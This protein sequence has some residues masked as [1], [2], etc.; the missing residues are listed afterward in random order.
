MVFFPMNPKT[1]SNHPSIGHGIVTAISA[2]AAARLRSRSLPNEP[3]EEASQQ[4][5]VQ[6]VQ[7]DFDDSEPEDVAPEIHHNLKLC[8]W[9]NDEKNVLSDSP[10]ELTILLNRN[11]TISLIGSYEIIVLKGAV[12]INGANLAANMRKDVVVPP[13]RVFVPLTHPISVVKGLD[14]RNEVCFTNCEIPTPL[15]D[16]SPL[17]ASIWN[18][19]APRDQKRSFSVVS[20]KDKRHIWIS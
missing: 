15:A 10:S 5:P 13:H 12:S 17:Y 4:S 18:S 1:A 3:Q 20:H 14:S 2:I 7:S 9:Q 8:T 16:I 11:I 19:H 6:P